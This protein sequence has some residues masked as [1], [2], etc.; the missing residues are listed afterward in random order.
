M[1]LAIIVKP[2]CGDRLQR[3]AGRTYHVSFHREGDLAFDKDSWVILAVGRKDES[4][5]KALEWSM[6]FQAAQGV[7]YNKRRVCGVGKPPQ[8]HGQ[9]LVENNGGDQRKGAGF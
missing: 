4:G 7:G 8:C 5:R 9:T 1:R 3:I 6:T 2:P